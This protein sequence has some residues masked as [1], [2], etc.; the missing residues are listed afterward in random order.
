MEEVEYFSIKPEM[1][2]HACNGE[3]YPIRIL[4]IATYRIVGTKEVDITRNYC[5]IYEN[6]RQSKKPTFL[7]ENG[8]PCG[9]ADFH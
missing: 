7:S 4:A 3:K 1:V 5:R 6:T 8:L 9:K 2:L